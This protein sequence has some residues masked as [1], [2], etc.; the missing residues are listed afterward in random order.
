MEIE[1]TGW[2]DA[3]LEASTVLH[4]NRV[5]IVVTGDDQDSPLSLWPCPMTTEWSLEFI[6][7]CTGLTKDELREYDAQ[8]WITVQRGSALIMNLI[9][10]SFDLINKQ[11]SSEVWPSFWADMKSTPELES[12]LD[13]ND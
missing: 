7:N 12:L 6:S 8:G 11:G 5:Y 9:S 4:S 1:L 10:L 2:A 3:I 13:W